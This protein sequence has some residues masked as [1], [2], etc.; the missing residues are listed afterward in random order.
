MNCS[1]RIDK[2]NRIILVT[3]VGE[4]NAASFENLCSNIYKNALKQR[5][6]VIFDFTETNIAISV[7]EAYYW[8]TEH[9]DNIDIR[10]RRIPIAYIASNKNWSFL[11]FAETTWSNSGVIVKVF[12]NEKLAIKWLISIG[13]K[14]NDIEQPPNFQDFIVEC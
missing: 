9:M 12:K 14:Q 11:E 7:G 3:V 1:Y 13:Y 5:S 4:L 10:F 6:K 2:I 8:F